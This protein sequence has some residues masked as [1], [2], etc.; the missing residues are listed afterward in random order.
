LPLR[1]G[2]WARMSMGFGQAETLT[3]QSKIIRF[4]QRLV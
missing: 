3:V 2:G 4:Y 1:E